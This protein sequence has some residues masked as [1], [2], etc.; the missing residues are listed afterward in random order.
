MKLKWNEDKNESYDFIL[1][2]LFGSI[3]EILWFEIV[4]C[5]I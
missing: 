3:F 1:E 5:C 4:Y 2:S